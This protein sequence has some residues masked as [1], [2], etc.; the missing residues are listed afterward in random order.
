MTAWNSFNDE[1]LTMTWI[2]LHAV[3]KSL[4]MLILIANSCCSWFHFIPYSLFL[5]WLMYVIVILLIVFVY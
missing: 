3:N 4:A 5:P 2:E 1:N